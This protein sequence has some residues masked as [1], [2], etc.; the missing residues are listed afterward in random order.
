MKEKTNKHET[1]TPQ[2]VSWLKCQEPGLI[3]VEAAAPDLVARVAACVEGGSTCLIYNVEQQVLP[4]W[5]FAFACRWTQYWT[6]SS[7]RQPSRREVIP[8]SG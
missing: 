3:S 4:W 1:S 2:A 5:T 6:L 7:R 8:V